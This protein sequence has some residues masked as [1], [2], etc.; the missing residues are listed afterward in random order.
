MRESIGRVG[1]LRWSFSVGC[2]RTV[3]NCRRFSKF[4]VRLI[5]WLLSLNNRLK[6]QFHIAGKFGYDPKLETCSIL[7]DVNGRS[8]KTV[9]FITAF[10]IPCLIIIVCYARIFWVVHKWVALIKQPRVPIKR[11]CVLPSDRNSECDDMRPLRM[12]CRTIK[13]FKCLARVSRYQKLAI[14]L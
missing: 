2:S 4:G 9:L 7:N 13:D 12:L 1:S 14:I 6:F 3:S 11:F 8:S 10:L 5:G